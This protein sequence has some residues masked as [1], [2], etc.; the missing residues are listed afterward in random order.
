MITFKRSLF[1][2][3]ITSISCFLGCKQDYISTIADNDQ[4]KLPPRDS[5]WMQSRREKQDSY[6]NFVTR[7]QPLSKV[8]GDTILIFVFNVSDTSVHYDLRACRQYLEAFY[9]RPVKLSTYETLPLTMS[10]SRKKSGNSIQFNAKYAIDSLL[11]QDRFKGYLA[12]M[13]IT[14][15]D[16]YPGNDWNFVFGLASYTNRV[17]ITSMYRFKAKD[18][19]IQLSRLLKT[20][21]HEAGHMFGLRHCVRSECVMNGSN[22]I[23]E[24]D[25]HI[26]RLCSDCQQRLYYRLA[27]D[28]TKR[29]TDLMTVL[30]QY[31][32]AH[33]YNMLV[34]DKV[35]IDH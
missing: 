13:A 11:Q 7:Y 30:K 18:R 2:L 20:A 12:T 23:G 8:D 22:T 21:S 1:I 15:L 5:D 10:N 34:R 35:M 25:Q 26:L 28:P 9:Q 17:G 27:I 33:D 32:L 19:R 24:L 14:P 31:D 3:A 16:I 4:K 6:K 29:V